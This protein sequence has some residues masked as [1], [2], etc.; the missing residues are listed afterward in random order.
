MSKSQMRLAEVARYLDI[1]PA[2]LACAICNCGVLEQI[3]LPAAI[4]K[5]MPL[6]GRC[7]LTQ[8]IRLFRHQLQRHR[9]LS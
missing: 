8:D 9:H 2:T 1:S 7:W 3:P 4:D 6:S 5:T